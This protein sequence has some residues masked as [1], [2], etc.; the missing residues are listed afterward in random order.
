M[1]CYKKKRK[2]RILSSLFF[3]VF[4]VYSTSDQTPH[5]LGRGPSLFG[6]F[7]QSVCRRR[8]SSLLVRLCFHCQVRFQCLVFWPSLSF[9]SFVSH[10]LPE[11]PCYKYTTNTRS[12]STTWNYL[13]NFLLQQV[14]G[15]ALCLHI[16][17]VHN[18]IFAKR[19]I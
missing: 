12:V 6:T 19:Y 14:P 5:P 2:E 16:R 7:L 3:I 4:I 11:I 13:S 1:K 15:N 17:Y 18:N 10:C 9:L 8:L